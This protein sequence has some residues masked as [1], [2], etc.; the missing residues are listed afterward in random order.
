MDKIEKKKSIKKM[1]KKTKQIAIKR[2]KIKF[3]IRI[4][5]NKK[6]EGQNWKIKKNQENDKKK[7]AIKRLITRLDK[8]IKWSQMLRGWN[9]K[10]K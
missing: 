3:D 7:I 6:N 9:W 8:K 2:M 1:I 4:K 10:T 5:W